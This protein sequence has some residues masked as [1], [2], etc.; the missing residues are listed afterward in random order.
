MQRVPGEDPILG[1][2]DT[3]GVVRTIAEGWNQPCSATEPD[4]TGSAYGDE[5]IQWRT[6]LDGGNG[7]YVE[8]FDLTTSPP[9][10]LAEYNYSPW[11]VHDYGSVLSAA[12]DGT[13]VVFDI[14]NESRFFVYDRALENINLVR[15]WFSMD[16][17]KKLLGVIDG[18]AYVVN[19]GEVALFDI[20]D[21]PLDAPWAD[22][23]A[24][25]R[26]EHA[27]VG[28]GDDLPTLLASSDQYLLARDTPGRLY[29]VPAL[30]SGTIEPMRFFAGE[31]PT[32]E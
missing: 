30:P 31:P 5:W 32:C 8:I 10:T 1:A 24:P 25:L 15:V 11:G 6:G 13:H 29:L 16:G 17:P 22:W 9:T 4:N 12:S 7:G 28:F 2:A 3:D 27:E 19:A 21:I 18:A 23:N 26:A 20:G 14:G